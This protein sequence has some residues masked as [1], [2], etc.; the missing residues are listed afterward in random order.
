MLCV[1]PLLLLLL[2]T[3][4]P[5]WGQEEE[6]STPRETDRFLIEKITV[7]GPKQAAANIIRS[8]TLLREGGTYT[9]EQLRLAIYRIHRLPFVLDASFALRRGSRRGAYELVIEA[10]PAR[11][12]F[13]DTSAHTF[14]F[15]EPLDLEENS[16]TLDP[17]MRS[18]TTIPGLVGARLFVG[19]SGVLFGALDSEEG[20]QA[21]FTQY[22]LFHRGILASAGYSR[23]TCCVREV[24]P[25]ALD[26]TFIS[27]SFQSSEKLSLGVAVPLGRRQS[28]Q[29]SLSERR[30]DAGT[31]RSVLLLDSPQSQVAVF[32]GQGTL[33]YRR[34][35]VKWVYDTSDDPLLPTRGYSL[36]AGLEAARFD[37]KNLVELTYGP[38][39]EDD[40]H[41]TVFPPFHG[42]DVVAAVSWIRHWPV[43]QR[44]TLSLT[45]RL[46]QGRSRLENLVLPGEDRVAGSLNLDTV[47]GSVGFQHAMTLKRTRRASDFT[48]LRLETGV[49]MGVES[50][51][52]DLGPSPLRRF[53]ASVGLVFRNQ[54]GR[55][56]ATFSYLDLGSI[57]P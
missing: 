19:R 27:W 54:W 53:T 2:F 31:R 14:R 20:I 47:G 6:P 29:I 48:D 55:V 36:S 26:P 23:N 13:F 8:E 5:A 11:W 52:L 30:G 44:Q 15:A 41:Q 18:S 7:E 32:K 50:N 49:E 38:P 57:F 39:P 25:L 40:H 56:R 37:T 33:A 21:G 45:S 16:F 35:E 4:L 28:V 1:R 10:K 24:L 51:R 12:F 22:D 43:G 3:A 46:F 9:E 17:T 34:A 42:E